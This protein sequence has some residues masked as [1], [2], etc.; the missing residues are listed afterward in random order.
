MNKNNY[1]TVVNYFG[2]ESGG[3]AECVSIFT[4]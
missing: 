1:G 3:N 4:K 2:S